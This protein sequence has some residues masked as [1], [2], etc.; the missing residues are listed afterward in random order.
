MALDKTYQTYGYT[1]DK[2]MTT[3][4]E[5]LTKAE[6]REI[7]SLRAKGAAGEITWQQANEG[8]NAIRRRHGYTIGQ[9]GAVEKTPTF[10]ETKPAAPEEEAAEQGGTVEV[11]DVSH[12]K[13]ERADTAPLVEALDTWRKEQETAHTQAV[14]AANREAAAELA[15]AQQA[16]EEALVAQRA[17]VDLE[18]A[19]AKDDQALAAH[20]RG[21]RGG[22]GA[23]QYDAISAAAA[24]N[25]QAIRTQR[26]KLAESTAKEMAALRTKGEYEKAQALLELSQE[27]LGKLQE[28]HRWGQERNLSVEK[29]NA[30]LEQWAAEY[31]LDA[32][33]Q[34]LSLKEF[35]SEQAAARDKQKAESGEMLLK[36]GVLPSSEQL[37]AMGMT[38]TE[39]RAYLELKAAGEKKSAS[40]SSTTPKTEMDIEGLFAAAAD[41]GGYSWLKQK[42]NYTKFGLQSAPSKADYDAWAE[43]HVF[44]DAE[45]SAI[46]K[47]WAEDLYKRYPTR[48]ERRKVIDAEYAVEDG[49]MTEKDYYYLLHKVG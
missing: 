26:R 19:R 27:Y 25:R 29:F 33:K 7:A 20:L 13:A 8:A 35:Q 3:D 4:E 34:S 23:A 49:W 22:I 17:A 6:L 15:A 36:L 39:A 11:P 31:A 40:S 46:A 10:V 9:D 43:Q 41:K 18:E 2:H 5:T 24:Q 44:N 12:L 1:T 28:I 37:A 48:A 21:D 42:S 14:D 32:E 16:G 45:I 47:G 30:Q 38:E